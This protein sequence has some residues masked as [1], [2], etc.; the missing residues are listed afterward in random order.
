MRSAFWPPRVGRTVLA[1]ALRR[2]IDLP[3][4]ILDQTRELPFGAA[5]VQAHPVAHDLYRILDFLPSVN[6]GDLYCDAHAAHRWLPTS[7][8]CAGTTPGLTC[9]P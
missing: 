8:R 6:D 2:Q 7:T 4:Q 3:L 5:V 1:C 9:A